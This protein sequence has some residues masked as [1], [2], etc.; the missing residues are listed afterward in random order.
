MSKAFNLDDIISHGAQGNRRVICAKQS[1]ILEVE[2][3]EAA[4]R[5]LRMLEA[6][7]A[8]PDGLHKLGLAV[9]HGLYRYHVGEFPTEKENQQAIDMSNDFRKD[10]PIRWTIMHGPDDELCWTSPLRQGR[11][12][13]KTQEECE[14]AIRDMV[15]NSAADTLVQVHG[16]GAKGTYR[17]VAHYCYPV[18]FDPCGIVEGTELPEAVA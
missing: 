13:Y 1:M 17:A 18:H 4:I 5:D 7:G 8:E 15:A 12:T 14:Q 6:L 10:Y 11:Y 16:E 9:L 2:K 3:V